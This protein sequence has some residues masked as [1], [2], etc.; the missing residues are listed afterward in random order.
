MGM[1][2]LCYGSFMR[3]SEEQKHYLHKYCTVIFL[4]CYE[5]RKSSDL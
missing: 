1:P 4:M 5:I 2:C 3:V